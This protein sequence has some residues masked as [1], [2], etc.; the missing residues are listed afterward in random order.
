[1]IVMQCQTDG[2]TGMDDTIHVVCSED[3]FTVKQ[4]LRIERKLADG[5]GRQALARKYKVSRK[6]IERIENGLY[7]V[8]A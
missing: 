6:T 7:Y 5:R 4:V 8:Q 3:K 1:M 2:E